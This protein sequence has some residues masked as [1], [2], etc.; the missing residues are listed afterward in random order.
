MHFRHAFAGIFVLLSI[1]L[2]ASAEEVAKTSPAPLILLKTLAAETGDA[3]FD[4]AAIDAA[5]RRLY[6]ARGFGVTAVDL[7]SARVT[8]QF[9]T[10]DFH[11][12]L[13]G[14]TPA[15]DSF[16]ILVLGTKT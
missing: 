11:I 4:Y 12:S 8:R 16:R 9:P 10:A 2:H 13:K 1:A 7:D 6:V 14:I 5:S 3:R 15:D